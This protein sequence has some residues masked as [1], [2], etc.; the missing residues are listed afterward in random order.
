MGQKGRFDDEN[1]SVDE[2]EKKVRRDD[3]TE[4]GTTGFLILV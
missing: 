1:G 2:R 4:K 3:G